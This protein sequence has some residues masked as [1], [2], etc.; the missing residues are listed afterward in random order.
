MVYR[1]VLFVAVLESRTH[2]RG[3]NEYLTA[4][5]VQDHADESLSA[6]WTF[7]GEVCGV[8]ATSSGL[9]AMYLCDHENEIAPWKALLVVFALRNMVVEL[10]FQMLGHSFALLS[11]LAMKFGSHSQHCPGVLH[12]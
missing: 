4:F 3:L 12:L 1:L 7:G 5:Y 10:Y 2:Q 9:T 11:S 6:L 8:C